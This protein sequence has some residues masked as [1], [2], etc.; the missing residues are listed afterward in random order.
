MLYEL[1]AAGT[2]GLSG[3]GVVLA[4]AGAAFQ[5]VLGVAAASLCAVLLLVPG[6]FF[7]AF[8]RRLASRDLAL[9]HAAS[10]AKGRDS[11]GIQ[12]LADELQVPRA[13]ALRVLQV[14]IQEGTSAGR[15]EGATRSS[16]KGPPS[17]RRIDDVPR[18]H[19]G[20]RAWHS[21]P[22]PTRGGPA[23]GESIP[24]GGRHWPGASDGQIPGRD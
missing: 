10:F 5:Q 14:A 19:R 2:L 9:A 22:G 13:A 18:V 3:V 17:G 24:Q 4:V 23:E 20:R 6:L 11:I 1:L 8:S 21:R 15:S 16:P 12:D 7:L